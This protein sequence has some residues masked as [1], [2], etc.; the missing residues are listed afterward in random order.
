MH[1]HFYEKE[2]HHVLTCVIMGVKHRITVI[3]TAV[4]SPPTLIFKNDL[5]LPDIIHH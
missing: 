2:K 5:K 1:V 3:Q 4:P